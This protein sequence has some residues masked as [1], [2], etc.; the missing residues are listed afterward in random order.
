MARPGPKPNPSKAP[1]PLLALPTELRLQIHNYL[2]L[3]AH[4]LHG[5]DAPRPPPFRNNPPLPQHHHRCP[6]QPPLSAATACSSPT[7]S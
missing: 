3:C 5:R 1:F 7:A 6:Q 4:E 2:L